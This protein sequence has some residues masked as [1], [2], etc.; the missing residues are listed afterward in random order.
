MQDEW[1]LDSD[2]ICDLSL[3]ISTQFFYRSQELTQTHVQ[4]YCILSLLFLLLIYHLPSFTFI[5]LQSNF[6]WFKNRKLE[7]NTGI[8]CAS[9][10]KKLKIIR[11]ENYLAGC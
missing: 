6:L 7:L 10:Y 5:F 1:T 3:V 8:I 4:L 9:E 2:C 11:R